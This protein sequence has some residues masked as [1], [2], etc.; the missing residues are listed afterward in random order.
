[1]PRGMFIHGYLLMGEQKMSKSLGNVLDPFEVIDRFGADALRFYCFREVSF[2]QDGK[3]SPAG[4]EQRYE[5][6]LANDYG[7]LASRTLAMIERYRAGT[8]PEAEVDPALGA[9]FDGAAD[10]VRELLDEAQISQAL[11]EIWKL[12]RRLNRYVEEGRPWDLAKDEAS[13]D[14]LDLVLYNLAEGLRVVTLLLLPYVPE[15]S[16]RLLGALGEE[17]REI[18]ELGSRGGGAATEKLPPLFPKLE[19]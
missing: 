3:I 14:R 16:E 17:G 13:S 4:F 1:V 7:N 10:R 9:D 12:V 6:E 8:I 5:T 18:A 15:T 2:G 11:D 19:T